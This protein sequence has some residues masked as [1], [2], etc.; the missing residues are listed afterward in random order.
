MLYVETQVADS[1]RNVAV[2][3]QKRAVA[4]HSGDD[5]A[6]AIDGTNVPEAR[7][8][9]AALRFGD[10]LLDALVSA[11]DDE[12]SRL[13][14]VRVGGGKRVAGVRPLELFARSSCR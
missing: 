11:G 13:R 14:S 4:R 6:L 2:F 3:D 1:V 8:Q 5:R 10:E 7:N 9:E 12:V